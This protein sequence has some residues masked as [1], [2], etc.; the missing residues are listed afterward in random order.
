MPSGITRPVFFK[1]FQGAGATHIAFFLR[2]CFARQLA[3]SSLLKK[4]EEFCQLFSPGRTD[5]PHLCDPENGRGFF[6]G[7]SL[8][9]G[10]AFADAYYTAKKQTLPPSMVPTL[11][12]M[13]IWFR[14]CTGSMEAIIS[15]S[16]ISPKTMKKWEALLDQRYQDFQHGNFPRLPARRTVTRRFPPIRPTQFKEVLQWILC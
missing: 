13:P 8:P 3:S 6:Q 4:W 16:K 7:G 11:K 15:A 14:P 12:T 2:W 9:E 1:R 5:V 10:Q